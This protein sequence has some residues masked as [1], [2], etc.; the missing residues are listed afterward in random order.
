MW[1]AEGLREEPERSGRGGLRVFVRVA[2]G[3]R[4]WEEEV[5]GVGRGLWACWVRGRPCELGGAG[6]LWGRSGIYR[7]RG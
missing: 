6:G 2:M 4:A 5:G 7:A 3:L 1:G